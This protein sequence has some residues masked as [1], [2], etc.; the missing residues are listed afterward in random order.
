MF[1]TQKTSEGIL[2][3]IIV[4]GV[5]AIKLF[6]RSLASRVVY[7]QNTQQPIIPD[8]EYILLKQ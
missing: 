4:D 7:G 5:P 2:R 8:G 6:K 1:D 3:R